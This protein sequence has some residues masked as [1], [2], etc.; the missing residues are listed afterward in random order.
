[1]PG[2]IGLAENPAPTEGRGL[3]QPWF[4]VDLNLHLLFMFECLLESN[5]LVKFRLGSNH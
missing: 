3:V 1:M 5:K 4:T 2:G